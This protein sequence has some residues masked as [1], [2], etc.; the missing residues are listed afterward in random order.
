MTDRAKLSPSRLFRFAAALGRGTVAAIGLCP[1]LLLFIWVER[2]MALP[3]IG[4]WV[5]WPWLFVEGGL[6]WSLAWN[7]VTLLVFALVHSGL[8]GGRVPRFL[9]SFATGL[10]A[11]FMLATWQPTGV[12]LYQLVPS[13]RVASAI[14][15]LLYWG[16]LAIGLRS[17]LRFESFSVFVGLKLP[18]DGSDSAPRLTREGLYRWVR[19]PAY[20]CTIAA[21]VVTPMLSL[22]RLFFAIGMVLYLGVGIR[23]EERRLVTKFGDA[24]RSYQ[25]EVP[26]LWPKI[27]G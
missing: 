25:R 24:Y 5:G 26:A 22:D 3:W 19:H 20:L 15:V 21:W 11:L 2:N 18:A 6:G 7:G 8:A 4:T 17:L 23:L 27:R 9:Y 12:V 10:S 14:S 16:F 13:A 1:S